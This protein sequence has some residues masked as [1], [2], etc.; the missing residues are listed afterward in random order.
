MHIVVDVREPDNIKNAFER[1]F[2]DVAFEQLPYGDVEINGH[3]CIERKTPF[4]FIASIKDGRLFEQARGIKE[5]Y[6]VPI[7]VV[8]GTVGS[9]FVNHIRR[10]MGDNAILGAIVSLY[11]KG[12]PVLF[13][14]KF[15]MWFIDRVIAHEEKHP[16]ER[17]VFRRK[18][19]MS[20]LEVIMG[21][22]KI[23][24]K[25]ARAILERFGSVK[26]AIDNIDKWA[27]IDGIGN[28]IVMDINDVL[29]SPWNEK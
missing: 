28:K 16:Q 25:R 11:T 4:D 27:E 26:N 2:P 3:I 24:E 19:V 8:T 14:D 21:F 9:L 29:T 15:F 13:V 12:V 5:N 18:S 22:P 6:D 17:K 1:K 20:A 23:G 10:G 7:I